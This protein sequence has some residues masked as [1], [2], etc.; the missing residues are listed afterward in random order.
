[1]T[2]GEE[3]PSCDKLSEYCSSADVSKIYNLY[4]IT[5]VSCWASYRNLSP[6]NDCQII[7]VPMRE[8]L[9]Q[10]RDTRGNAVHD[11]IGEMFI[12]S[13]SRVCILGDEIIPK[14]LSDTK[15]VPLFRAT[16]DLVQV[17][18]DGKS[19]RFLGR[20]DRIVKRWGQKI[21]LALIEEAARKNACVS[22]CC[23]IS[24][25]QKG[26][27]LFYQLDN[28]KKGDESELRCWLKTD[29]QLANSASIP[30]ITVQLHEMPLN[31]NG[32]IDHP[33]INHRFELPTRLNLEKF[34][35]LHSTISILSQMCSKS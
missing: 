31:S 1:M 11:G 6:E 35:L 7:G 10:V 28:F 33:N 9:L 15:T 24:D 8:T 23:C 25:D 18:N 29:G 22:N 17:E 34:S 13:S 19:F 14:I 26:L 5:E 4:G 12:G 2:G 27:V 3:C 21:N 32:K 16:G 20:K 30:D